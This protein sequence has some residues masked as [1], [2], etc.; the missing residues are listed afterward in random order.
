MLQ[1]AAVSKA[2]PGPTGGGGGTGVSDA[3]L[4]EILCEHVTATLADDCPDSFQPRRNFTATVLKLPASV[5]GR[6]RICTDLIKRT[7]PLPKP[8]APDYL[9]KY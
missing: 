6:G 8:P 4:Q 7:P 1:C 2:A 5:D 9:K 3:S